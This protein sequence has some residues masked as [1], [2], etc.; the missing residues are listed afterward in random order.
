MY[1]SNI[2]QKS[3]ILLLMALKFYYDSEFILF[4]FIYSI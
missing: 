3:I 2:L 4:K 1:P